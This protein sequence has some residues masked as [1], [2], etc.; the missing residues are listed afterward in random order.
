MAEKQ[1]PSAM[2]DDDLVKA[3]QTEFANALGRPG[4]T[5][6]NDRADLYNSYLSKPLGNEVEGQSKVV[7]AD[8]AEI[9]D[10]IMPNLLRIFAAS[11]NLV[12]FDP[13]G[14]DDVE[15]AAQESDVVDYVFFKQNPAFLILYSWFF[16]ALVQ[17]NG[18]V[19]C[20]WDESEV[21][22]TETYE[23]L[24]EQSAQILMQDD[25]L[26][27]LEDETRVRVETQTIDVPTAIGMVPMQQ[28]V[29]LYDVK[30]RRTA[31]KGRVRVANVP[32]EEYRISDDA[33]C[34]DPASGRM[35][36]QEREVTR[37][38]LLEMGIPKKVVS[39]LSTARAEATNSAEGIARKESDVQQLSTTDPQDW[40][41]EKVTVCEGYYRVDFDGDGYAELRKV[42]VSG[43]KLL[44]NELCDRTAFHVLSPTP[45]PHK[46]FGRA[47]AEK[48]KD[49]QEVN[50]TLLRQV[51]TNLYHTNQPGHAVWEQ[52][53]GEDTLDDLLDTR[54][55][56]IARF[57][58]PV[59]EAYREMTVPFT[60]GATFPMFEYFDKLKRDRTGV[61]S[62]SE[63][64]S[65]DALKNIQTTV[66]SQAL[67]NAKGKIEVIARIFAE[68]GIKSLML[69]IHELL[70][71]HQD[72]AMTVSLRGKFIDVDPSEWRERNDMTVKV[73]VGVGSRETNL[74]HITSI[75]DRQ[76]ALAQDEKLSM[77]VKPQ[78]VYQS[79]LSL[80]KNANQPNPALFWTDP[81][82]AE[83][84]PPSAEQEQLQAQQQQLQQQQQEL[85]AQRQQNE[86]A[87]LE[88]KGLEQTISAK[89]RE[90]E[91]TLKHVEAMERLALDRKKANDDL[92]VRMDQIAT[93]LTELELTTGRNVPGAKV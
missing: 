47:I 7:T 79:L 88:L 10:S 15:A 42:M 16:D 22:T 72:K 87:K 28:P 11:E 67:D 48:V 64:L 86:A 25:E 21:Q 51:L 38:S 34:L 40:A 82:D 8:V 45:L 55:G 44:V 9:I 2:T 4:T 68:T 50:T 76:M 93:K 80:V 27:L 3:V 6:S 39:S 73:G 1:G 83:M 61:A 75:I 31:K 85:I 37:C 17:K 62:D 65:P 14:E 26:E 90:V 12:T 74:L 54:I 52:G 56:R 32:V 43:D 78:N 60:A 92:V 13:E 81:G 57:A 70:L 69:H 36:G 46:H 30:F 5:L 20:W 89:Q 77:L 53:I 35:S 33:N 84:P 91:M 41:E 19:K 29:T 66:L 63:G 49:I 59:N 24:D 18:V 58:R 23:G 71:K